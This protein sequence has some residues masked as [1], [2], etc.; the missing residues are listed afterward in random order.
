MAEDIE[1]GAVARIHV[2]QR[3][4]RSTDV[5]NAVRPCL[6]R[7]QD[8]IQRSTERAIRRGANTRSKR[9]AVVASVAHLAMYPNQLQETFHLEPMNWLRH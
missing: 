3:I 6:P 5:V 7:R 4:R 1:A 2:D 9:R 8:I